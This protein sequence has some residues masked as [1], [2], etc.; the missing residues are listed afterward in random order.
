M[1]YGESA[2]WKESNIKKGQH[3]KSATQKE[4]KPEKRNLK[5]LQHGKSET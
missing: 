5:R 2:I 4:S 1:Q 3:E